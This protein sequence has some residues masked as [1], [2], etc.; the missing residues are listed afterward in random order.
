MGLSSIIPDIV[1]KYNFLDPHF[2]LLWTT[3][4]ST[5]KERNFDV[6]EAYFYHHPSAHITILASHLQQHMFDRFT[7]A[8]YNISVTELSDSYLREL[9][10][11]CPGKSWID[12]LDR[13]KKGP[14]YYS[15]I[16]DYVR[17]CL[18]YQAGGIYSDFDAI[19]IN[20]INEFSSFIGKDSAGA[21]S[22]CEWCLSG[23]D[24]Y[25]VCQHL[26]REFSIPP[27]FK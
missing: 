26:V 4:P 1:S 7:R 27:N 3:A 10:T 9:S 8:G 6:L 14:Y 15:H 21:Y 22:H 5:F 11:H 12:H 17:F 18:L 24:T 16:T 19:L 23:G 20:R 2:Y 25:L 13:W